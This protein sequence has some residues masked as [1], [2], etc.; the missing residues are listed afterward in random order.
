M[1]VTSYLLGKKS[2]G[3]TPINNQNKNV[4]ITENGSTTVNADAGYTGLGTVGIS[5]N[6]QPDLET[7]SVTITENGSTTVT[8]T[9]GKDGLT[10]VSITTNVPTSGPDLSDYFTDTITGGSNNNGG[11]QKSVKQMI[12]PTTIVGGSLRYAYSGFVGTSLDMSRLNTSDV[13]YFNGMFSN[14]TNLQTMDISNF[15]LSTLDPT[16]VTGI[17]EMFSGCQ[18]IT[19]VKMP[20][21]GTDNVLSAQSLFYYCKKLKTVDMSNFDF[22]NCTIISS[23]FGNCN[24]LENLTFGT[25]LGRGYPETISPG[26]NSN[27]TLN[28]TSCTKLTHDS[29]I[30]VLNGL[31][32]VTNIT[33]SSPWVKLGTDNYNKLSASEIAIGTA[34]GWT[35]RE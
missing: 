9:Q 18:N 29:L 21:T 27:Q 17:N 31:Y 1:D 24:D 4:T 15:D 8:P 25:N 22:S 2:G 20:S 7:K 32:D 14:C 10:E 5:T 33:S 16:E 23:M 26:T 11:F 3:G 6:V 35:V 19:Y 34:K 13:R 12:P 28:L 30:S